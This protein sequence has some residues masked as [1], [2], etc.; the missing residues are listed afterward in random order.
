MTLK[1]PSFTLYLSSLIMA[2]ALGLLGYLTLLG[3]GILSALIALVT[4]LLLGHLS[5][6]LA[7]PSP[8]KQRVIRNATATLNDDETIALYIGNLSYS[9]HRNTLQALFE[10]CGTVKSVRIMTDRITHRPRGFAFVEMD[11]SGARTAM[12]T[13]DNSEFCGRTLRVSEAKQKQ[14]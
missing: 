12:A 9:A 4:G 2:A 8:P 5:G 6:V 10:T 3:L 1:T 7:S 11:S 14:G 13:L